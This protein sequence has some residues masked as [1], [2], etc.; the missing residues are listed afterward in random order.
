VPS[1]I[2]P[3]FA[4][5]GKGENHAFYLVHEKSTAILMSVNIKSPQIRGL[6]SIHTNKIY[7]AGTIS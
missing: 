6:Y 5:T 2:P 3:G 4:W 7:I 1:T